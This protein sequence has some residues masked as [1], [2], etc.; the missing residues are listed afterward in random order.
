MSI[1]TL[2][3]TIGRKSNDLLSDY[4][5]A[6]S[7][8]GKRQNPDYEKCYQTPNCCTS[9]NLNPKLRSRVSRSGF[10]VC[11]AVNFLNPQLFKPELDL[12]LVEPPH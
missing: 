2:L 6:S 4:P 8:L 3:I 10:R 9:Q 7:F 12:V 5:L 11:G 1:F